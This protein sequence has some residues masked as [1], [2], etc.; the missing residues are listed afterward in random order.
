ME[1]FDS[2]SRL[3][4]PCSREQPLSYEGSALSSITLLAQEHLSL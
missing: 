2:Y 1:K 3:I 4:E